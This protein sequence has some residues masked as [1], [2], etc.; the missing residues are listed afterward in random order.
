MEFIKISPGRVHPPIVPNGRIYGYAV[1]GGTQE[2]ELFEIQSEGIVGRGISLR[3]E[4][5]TGVALDEAR[6]GILTKKY[7]SG[8]IWFRASG[9]YMVDANDEEVR[10][11]QGYGVLYTILNRISYEQQQMQK[12]GEDGRR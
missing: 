12:D 6:C 9:L 11:I 1:A 2:A 8:G 3:W 10:T 4:E 5:I 7:S